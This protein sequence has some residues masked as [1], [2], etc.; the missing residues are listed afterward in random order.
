LRHA[1]AVRE[2]RTPSTLGALHAARDA[3]LVAAA[4]AAVLEQAWILASRVRNAVVLFRG[5]SSDSLP[6]GVR[7]L[8]GVARLVGYPPASVVTFDDD[9]QRVTRRARNVVDRLFYD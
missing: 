1:G 9:Y 3:G 7:E 8:D 4:D 5:R 2:L 6:T